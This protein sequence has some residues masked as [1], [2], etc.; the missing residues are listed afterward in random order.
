MN[1]PLDDAP[2]DLLEQARLRLRAEHDANRYEEQS[3]R[4]ARRLVVA[5]VLV[6]LTAVAFFVV[7][8]LMGVDLP[9]IVPVMCFLTILVGSVLAHAGDA[10]EHHR[11]KTK[12]SED[13]GCAV[14]CCPGP[15]PLKMFRDED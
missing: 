15:R 11:P 13:C 10:P 12:Q 8:P 1:R 4:L 5:F 6:M 3:K 2:D 7:V 14:G 9:L